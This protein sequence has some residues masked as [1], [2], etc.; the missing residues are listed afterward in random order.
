MSSGHKTALIAVVG[1]LLGAL[2][3]G[4]VTYWGNL[5]LQKDERDDAAR[6]VARVLQLQLAVAQGLL[7]LYQDGHLRRIPADVGVHI[8]TDAQRLLAAALDRQQ[9]TQVSIGLGEV[10]RIQASRSSVGCL[11]ETIR[12]LG[13]VRD[14]IFRAVR[15]LSPLSGVPFADLR[16]GGGSSAIRR[17]P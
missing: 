17:C 3:G 10:E 12:R 11:N 7:G 6:G 2:V 4:G 9:W 5:A 14:S 8:G 15:A 16:F 1:T 13:S